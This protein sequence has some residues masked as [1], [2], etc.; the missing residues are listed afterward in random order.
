M[1]AVMRSCACADKENLSGSDFVTVKSAMNQAL[2][3]FVAVELTLSR[4]F[5][6]FGYFFRDN[7]A[8]SSP[9]Y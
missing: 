6:S 5:T 1:Q 9:H 7:P 4:D 2:Q 8:R 3:S